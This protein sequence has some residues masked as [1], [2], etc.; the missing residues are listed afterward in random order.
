MAAVLLVGM[1]G[2]LQPA[3]AAV[4][5][6]HWE[7]LFGAPFTDLDWTAEAKFVVP[8]SCLATD[9]TYGSNNCGGFSTLEGFITFSDASG[10]MA[11][12]TLGAKSF[13]MDNFKV[14]GGE[15]SGVSGDFSAVT[16]VS[17]FAGGGTY[18][19]GLE[20]DGLGST[21]LAKT[22]ANHGA[23]C[24]ELSPGTC[25]E[26]ANRGVILDGGFVNISAVPEPET[27]ALLLAGLGAI[28]FLRKRR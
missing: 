12:E 9:G 3:Q 13:N 1:L 4:Y 20:L 23:F 19:F 2:A 16:P 6:G 24:T 8:D 27:Y 7:P 15:L 10:V 25:V 28:G 18:S 5:V 14:L 21:L 22:P 26:S 17:A 11:S